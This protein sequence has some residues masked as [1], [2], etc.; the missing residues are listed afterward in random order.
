VGEKNQ[1]E[2][3]KSNGTFVVK[4]ERERERERGI[5]REKMKEC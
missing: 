2:S 5:N 3:I 1:K 4:R